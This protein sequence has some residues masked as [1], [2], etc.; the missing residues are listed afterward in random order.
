M[1]KTRQKVL[2]WLMR[3]HLDL[4]ANPLD[5]NVYFDVAGT[6][7]RTRE[8]TSCEQI[9]LVSL[10]DVVV[11]FMVITQ[12]AQ[13]NTMVKDIGVDSHGGHWADPLMSPDDHSDSP[14]NIERR[15]IAQKKQ[16]V[17]MRKAEADWKLKQIEEQKKCP[18]CGALKGE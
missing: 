13:E 14:V 18:H 8:K 9:S 17:A 3:R 12:R 1:H 10:L 2:E 7:G 6:A 5:V 4:E 11:A 15:A 16:E